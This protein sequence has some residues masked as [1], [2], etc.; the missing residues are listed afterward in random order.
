[1]QSLL[2]TNL[3]SR[4][5]ELDQMRPSLEVQCVTFLIFGNNREDD[6]SP[7]NDYARVSARY[8]VALGPTYMMQQ[9]DL[10]WKLIYHAL[11]HVDYRGGRPLRRRCV[12][13]GYFFQQHFS[14]P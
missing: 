9:T 3:T 11:S 10:P 13:G 1:L 5:P 4:H 8:H 12:S 6:L 7:C 14:W 2:L